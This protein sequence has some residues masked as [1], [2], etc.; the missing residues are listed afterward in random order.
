MSSWTNVPNKA[1]F[2][3]VL[4]NL[5]TFPITTM[6]LLYYETMKNWKNKYNSTTSVDLINYRKVLWNSVIFC[7]DRCSNHSW[8]RCPN[9]AIPYVRIFISHWI[10]FRFREFL[11]YS[12]L[13]F[14]SWPP[15]LHS[16]STDSDLI[17]DFFTPFKNIGRLKTNVLLYF[18]IKIQSTKIVWEISYKMKGVIQWVHNF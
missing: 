13:L 17:I 12:S 15:F 7:T 14:S 9:S 1:L 5:I 11:C 6:I 18:F 16:S 8:F 3:L 10:C 4:S 2:P